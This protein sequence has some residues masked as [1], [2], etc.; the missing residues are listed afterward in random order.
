MKWTIR[1]I[2]EHVDEIVSLDKTYDIESIIK[3]RDPSI[4]HLDPVQVTGYL[5]AHEQEVI[6]HCQLKTKIILPSTRTFNPVTLE[7]DIPIKERY[8]YPDYDGN[9]DE[10]EETTIVLEHDYI[11]LE[12]ALIDG[13]LLN[14]PFKII[15]EDEVDSELPTGTGWAVITEEDY[16]KEKEQEQSTQIDPRFAALKTLQNQYK[17][18]E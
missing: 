11:D 10:Y 6:L 13:I 9:V 14:L 18:D 7:M 4:I 15:S 12:P 3:K 8:V 1:Q 17:E 5:V 16:Q 2:R